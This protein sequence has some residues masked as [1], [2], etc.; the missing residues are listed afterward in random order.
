MKYKP[1]VPQSIGELLDQVG[2]MMLAAPTFKDKTGYFPQKSIHTAFLSLNEG[3]WVVRKELGEERYVQLKAISD[4]MRVLFEADPDDDTGDAQAAR[5]LVR[6][7]ED[8]LENI[9][10]AAASK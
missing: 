5:K 10:S 4:K 1:Y 3:L 8:I 7:M 9:A 2:Y 6:E